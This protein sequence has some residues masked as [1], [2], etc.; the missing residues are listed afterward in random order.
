MGN[1]IMAPSTCIAYSFIHWRLLGACRANDSSRDREAIRPVIR[2]YASLLLRSLSC[3]TA[4]LFIGGICSYFD[5]L[6]G[7]FS[8]LTHIFHLLGTSSHIST[9]FR[10][11]FWF[12]FF[13]IYRWYLLL[14]RLAFGVVFLYH[15]YFFFL[16]YRGHPAIFRLI[17]RLLSDF[18]SF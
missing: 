8:D 9:Y 1:V 14:F 7:R 17:L 12:H 16:I 3:V 13:Y 15:S 6:L 5:S 2:P 4:F 10:A 18:T 11:I